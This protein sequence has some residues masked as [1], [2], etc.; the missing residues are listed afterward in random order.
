M[1]VVATGGH[2]RGRADVRLHLE[3]QHVAVERQPLRDVADVQV[4]VAR[5][6]SLADLGGRLLAV[7]RGQQVVEGQRRRPSGVAEVAG[8]CSRGRSAASSIP[9]PSGSAR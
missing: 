5:P 2:E 9:L 8:H 1:V 3:A 7:H 4:Q 6:Q